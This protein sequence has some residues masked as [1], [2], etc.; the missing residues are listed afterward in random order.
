MRNRFMR[1]GLIVGGAT[2]L[3]LAGCKSSTQVASTKQADGAASAVTIGPE[4]SLQIPTLEGANASID[5]YKGKVVLVNFWATWCQP[6]NA[7]IPELIEYNQK[8]GPRGLVILGV[9]MDEE[10]KRVVD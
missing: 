7:E 4:E 1:L 3:A 10:G 6:C 9:A 5:Q 8:Y 2:L